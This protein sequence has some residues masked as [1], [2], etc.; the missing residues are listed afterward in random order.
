MTSWI[1]RA[2]RVRSSAR[3]RWARSACRA[4]S[5]ST[6]TSWWRT[7]SAAST[8]KT[9]PPIHGPQPGSRV[10]NAHSAA[11]T[12]AL[13][14]RKAPP[15]AGPASS[16]HQPPTT[17]KPNQPTLDGMPLAITTTPAADS[18]AH[19]NGI[20]GAVSSKRAPAASAS[21]DPAATATGLAGSSA[22]SPA[23]TNQGAQQHAE[24]GEGDGAQQHAGDHSNPVVRCRDAVH[25]SS[26]RQ[27]RSRRDDHR[28]EAG[29]QL[30]QR[31]RPAGEPTG[32][33][34][35]EHTPLAVRGE[36]HRQHHQTHG[37]DD[38]GEVRGHVPVRRVDPAERGIRLGAEG[39][40]DDEHGDHWEGEDEDQGER[41]APH[42][43]QFS[44]DEPSDRAVHWLTPISSGAAA[45]GP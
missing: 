35:T 19:A 5:R 39:T 14:A 38:N 43:L 23:R 22:S 20:R 33:K 41:L 13:A 30:R 36:V 40:T 8:V 27:Q 12:N 7:T 29:Q 25:R 45:P 16:A 26:H 1:S 18:A 21:T 44:A 6:S 17:Q 15:D 28:N 11:N 37:T 31:E 42:E 34:P 4:R 2:M 10:T 32:G 3:E 9:V 24:A